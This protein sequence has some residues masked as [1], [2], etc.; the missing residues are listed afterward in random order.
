VG[1]KKIP[2]WHVGGATP[3][4]GPAR[5]RASR[6]ASAAASEK[7]CRAEEKDTIELAMRDEGDEELG[8]EG[9]AKRQNSAPERRAERRKENAGGGNGPLP[10]AL[11]F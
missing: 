11:L 5:P 1:K 10:A 8:D 2:R 3:P 9:C 4:P 6:A 7:P